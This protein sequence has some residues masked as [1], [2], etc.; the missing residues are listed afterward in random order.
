M[1]QQI[2]K[3]HCSGCDNNFYNDNNPYG[4]KECWC[5]KKAKLIMRKKVHVDQTP[6]WKQKPTKMPDCYRQRRYAFI[7]GDREC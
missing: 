1:K 4:V 5:L 6:P 2:D 3:K 7:S